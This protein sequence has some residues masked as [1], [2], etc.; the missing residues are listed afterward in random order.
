MLDAQAKVQARLAKARA[1]FA[2]G[3]EDAQEVHATL[4]WT[5]KQVSY[6]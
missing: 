2:E 4:E 5:Q 6:V 3:M 1:R